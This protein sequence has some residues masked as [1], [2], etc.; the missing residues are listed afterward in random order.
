MNETLVTVV[1][2]VFS[3]INKRHT[4]SGEPGAAFRVVSTERRYDKE[5]REWVDG[6]Q[7]IVSVSCWRRLALGVITSLEKGDPVIVRGRLHTR[8]YAVEGAT[9]TSADLV[10]YQ[11]GPDLSRCHAGVHRPRKTPAASASEIAESAGQSVPEQ[12]GVAPTAD[13]S[14]VLEPGLARPASDQLD[15]ES[16]RQEVSVA[17]P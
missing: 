13:M 10:A 12:R 15:D 9:R 5:A 7:L 3:P 11:V 1:G 8:T 2:Y 16:S 6:D 17:A 4:S 14:D